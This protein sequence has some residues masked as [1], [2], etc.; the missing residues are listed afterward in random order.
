MTLRRPRPPRR[1]ESIVPM[2]NVVFLLQIFFLM[3][4]EIAPPEP[5]A[6]DLPVAETGSAPIGEGVLY[7][8]RDGLP[9]FD[10]LTGDPA[11]ARLGLRGAE[12]GPLQIRADGRLEAAVL[13][14]LLGRLAATGVERVEVMVAP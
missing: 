5:F 2:I 10:G 14:R 7:V 8:N 4:A 11:L 3:V 1:G 13:A 12:A 6:V 9:G